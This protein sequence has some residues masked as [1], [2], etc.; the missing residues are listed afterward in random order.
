MKS[1]RTKRAEELIKRELSS[2]FNRELREHKFGFITVT[3]VECSPDLKHA[4][5][6]V[7][8]MEK[9]EDRETIKFNRIKRKLSKIRSLLA[10]RLRNMRYVPYL[11]VT[12]DKGLDKIEMIE[13]LLDEDSNG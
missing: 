10:S 11:K 8:I 1:R 7:S 5:F 12:L 4:E 13:K 3:K 9:D 6:F 2:I